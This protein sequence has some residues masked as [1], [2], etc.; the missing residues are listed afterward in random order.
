MTTF[1]GHGETRPI[2]WFRAARK[3]VE[4]FPE[5]VRDRLNTAL[6]IAA[7]GGKAD[8]AKPLKR[9]GPGVMQVAVR[10]RTDAYRL[11]YVTEVSG[12]L[13]VIHAFQKKSRTGIRTPKREIDLVGARLGRLRKEVL[14]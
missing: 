9:L 5:T 8:I 13:W 11:V 1:R 12:T 6:T 4:R 3:A 2:G 10:Y 14:R 7:E